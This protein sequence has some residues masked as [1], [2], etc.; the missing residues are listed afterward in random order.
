MLILVSYDKTGSLQ[1]TGGALIR[2]GALNW[3]ITVDV[4]A[5]SQQKM[6]LIFLSLETCPP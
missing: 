3:Q 6:V 5:Q 2:G 1:T 4:L